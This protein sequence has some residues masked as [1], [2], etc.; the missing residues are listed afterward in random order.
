ML[1]SAEEYALASGGSVSPSLTRRSGVYYWSH[2]GDGGSLPST[3]GHEAVCR[4]KAGWHLRSFGSH[5]RF[6]RAAAE[7]CGPRNAGIGPTLADGTVDSCRGWSL[8]DL[9][10]DWRRAHVGGNRT[11]GAGWWRWKPYYMLSELRKLAQGDVLV[12][13]DYDI[14][15]AHNPSALFCLG[16]QAPQGV[17]TFHFP[18][19]TDRGWT[20]RET[21][22]ALGATDAMLDTATLYAG[23][24]AVR[25]TPDAEAFLE[26]WLKWALEGELATDTLSIPQDP[27]FREH[28]HDQT[29]LSLVAKRRHIKSYP[30]PTA[31][32]DVRDV[33]AWEAGYCEPDFQWPLPNYRP[34]IRSEAWPNGVYI[35][36]YKEM[37]RMK[38]S[39]VHCLTV[40]PTTKLLPLPDYVD[41]KTAFEEVKAIGRLQRAVS[42]GAITGEGTLR[43]GRR[44][45]REKEHITSAEEPLE[46]AVWSPARLTSAPQPPGLALIRQERNHIELRVGVPDCT[47]GAS[48][49]GMY[50]E[51]RPYLW[52]ANYCHGV[53]E[54]AGVR[55]RC[56]GHDPRSFDWWQSAQLRG[57]G[58]MTVCACNEHE[59]LLDGKHF[60]DGNDKIAARPIEVSIVYRFQPLKSR[61]DP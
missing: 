13:V 40:E 53:F 14:V 58:R 22:L 11:R 16:Q 7:K 38:E 37:G 10:E 8:K 60:W 25:R 42:Q 55:L 35:M 23:I 5:G 24:V 54:C 48:F 9:P 49:G 41:S 33:W 43:R 6:A 46:Q 50:Y 19:L 34:W 51:N 21:A 29:I 32:H 15:L 30:F 31:M 52:I 57:L 39:I 20:K 59:S 44:A 26:E 28:R 27:A 36:H 17:A 12:H 45:Q 61:P 4:K 18:C 56:G 3:A 1:L 47:R 2:P